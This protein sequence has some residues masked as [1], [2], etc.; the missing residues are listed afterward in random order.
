M[1]IVDYSVEGLQNLV[2]SLA[3]DLRILRWTIRDLEHALSQ[4]VYLHDFSDVD[5]YTEWELDINRADLLCAEKAHAQ[6][7]RELNFAL[8]EEEK[9][10]DAL[11]LDR[12]MGSKRSWRMFMMHIRRWETRNNRRNWKRYRKHQNRVA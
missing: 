3:E 9:E 1:L 8:K 12:G 5:E 11:I 2:D 7:Q 6:A 4:A 10:I